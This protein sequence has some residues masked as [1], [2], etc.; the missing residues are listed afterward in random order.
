MKTLNKSF[1]FL[2]IAITLINCATFATIH[3]KVPLVSAQPLLIDQPDQNVESESRLLQTFGVDQSKIE[4][5]IYHLVSDINSIRVEKNIP[6]LIKSPFLNQIITQWS[7]T[8]RGKMT[9]IAYLQIYG[10]QDMQIY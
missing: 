3:Y 8:V 7:R 6:V 9:L 5:D 2:A 4:S 1:V 10:V